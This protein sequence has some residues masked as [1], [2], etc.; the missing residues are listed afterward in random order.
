MSGTSARTPGKYEVTME[1][2][3]IAGR[4]RATTWP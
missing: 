3:I 4:G 1:K 2:L